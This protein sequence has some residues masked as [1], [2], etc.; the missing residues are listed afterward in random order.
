MFELL[1]SLYGD[2][3]VVFCVE[4]RGTAPDEHNGRSG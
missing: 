2:V 3:R 1:A 4:L